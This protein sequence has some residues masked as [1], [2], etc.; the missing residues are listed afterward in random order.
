LLSTARTL[1]CEPIHE[2]VPGGGYPFWSISGQQ[3]EILPSGQRR[4]TEEPA[5][6]T[7]VTI[8]SRPNYEALVAELGTLVAQAAT[9]PAQYLQ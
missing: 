1:E 2:P 6:I 3:V 5:P 8:D 7:Q 9:L 4:S